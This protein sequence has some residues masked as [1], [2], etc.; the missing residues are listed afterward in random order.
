MQRGV[1][2]VKISDKKESG[3]KERGRFPT[4]TNGYTNKLLNSSFFEKLDSQVGRK[5]EKGMRNEANRELFAK[6]KN[7]RVRL[8]REKGGGRREKGRMRRVPRYWILSRGITS[9]SSSTSWLVGRPR[10]DPGTTLRRHRRRYKLVLVSQQSP[11]T[12]A[13]RLR[14]PALRT[15]ER[16][17]VTLFPYRNSADRPNPSTRRRMNRY[18]RCQE[19]KGEKFRSSRERIS[20][21]AMQNANLII[22][23]FTYSIY[24]HFI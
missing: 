15:N 3:G 19:R 9:T 10:R 20:Q 24:I 14:H 13:R 17:D 11:G 5:E 22:R 6:S 4:Q 1:L 23:H 7:K 21:L 18:R 16:D 8:G 12:T 2:R